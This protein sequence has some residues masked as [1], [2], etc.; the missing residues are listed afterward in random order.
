MMTN[1]HKRFSAPIF[2]NLIR[3]F[4]LL[5]FILPWAVVASTHV[6]KKQDQPQS[7]GSLSKIGDVYVNDKLLTVNDSTLFAG[8]RLRTA[9]DGVASFTVSGRGTLKFSPNTFVVFTGAE[10]YIAD[11]RSGTVVASSF[12]GPSGLAVRVG[13]HIVLPA[14]QDVQTTAKIERTVPGAATIACLEG[15]VSVITS[16]GAA[17]VLLQA[18]Q[19]SAISPEGQLGPASTESA[20]AVAPSP[21]LEPTEAPPA[22]TGTAPA[23]TP[24][25]ASNPQKSRKGWIILGLAA[26]GGAG[27]AAAAAGGHGNH[28][29]VSPSSP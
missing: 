16:E 25:P 8:D 28:Q 26:A 21:T 20:A 2:A 19:S 17:G 4:A 29:P 12:S 13:N 7:L 3:R 18:G 10:L 23:P 15:S 24:T 9:E 27:I 14:V 22:E 1:L 5:L 11:L 6:T